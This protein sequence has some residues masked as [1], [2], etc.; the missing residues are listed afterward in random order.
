MRTLFI[1]G[2]FVMVRSTASAQQPFY[3]DDA[4]V[5]PKGGVHVES[6]DEYDWLQ[7][8]QAPHLQ[9]NTINMRVNYGP[10]R[11]LVPDGHTKIAPA[12][13]PAVGLEVHDVTFRIWTKA[14][15]SAESVGR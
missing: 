11:F 1:V 2:L 10:E 13:T 8:S 9:Q 12:V 6:F 14:A 7:R 5:T 15:S 3:T 4:D